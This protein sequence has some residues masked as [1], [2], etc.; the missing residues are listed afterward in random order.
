VPA[1]HFT[2]EAEPSEQNPVLVEAGSGI[3]QR[4]ALIVDDEPAL[5]DILKIY[6]Q[7]E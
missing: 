2:R 6:L 5:V 7:D 4:R 3:K 1:I